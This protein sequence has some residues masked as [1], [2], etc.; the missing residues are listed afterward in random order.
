D[1]PAP[2]AGTDVTVLARPEAVVLEPHE[3]G[4]AVVAVAT[5]RGAIT[6]LRLLRADGSEL[7]ADVASHRASA[8]APGVRVTVALLDRPVLLAAD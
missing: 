5:F 8:L 1:G 6:R 7:L 4:E 3:H 2:A